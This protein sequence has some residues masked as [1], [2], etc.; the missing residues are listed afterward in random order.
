MLSNTFWLSNITHINNQ[1]VLD[2][3]Q[4]LQKIKQ[5]MLENFYKQQ[6][7]E[8]KERTLRLEMAQLK[9]E[10]FKLEQQIANDVYNPK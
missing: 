5:K 1:K 3:I 4:T 9:Q 8:V 7:L 6:E 2:N 10:E